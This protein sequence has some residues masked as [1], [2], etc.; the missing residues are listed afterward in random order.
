MHAVCSQCN[1]EVTVHNVGRSDSSPYFATH[2]AGWDEC[3]GS[4]IGVEPQAVVGNIVYVQ[5]YGVWISGTVVKW[6]NGFVKIDL[7]TGD[8]VTKP[9]EHVRATSP[10]FDG[11]EW[12]M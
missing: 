12:P 8:R 2:K 11:A 6:V 5:H 7:V 4:L 1:K 3:R 9:V 10:R